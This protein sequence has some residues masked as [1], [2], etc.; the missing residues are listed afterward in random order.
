LVILPQ[1]IDLKLNSFFLH[2]FR[3]RFDRRRMAMPAGFIL[4][5]SAV[6]LRADQALGAIA[7]GDRSE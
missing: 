2:C 1:C 5:N 7:K 4:R 6:T 3:K